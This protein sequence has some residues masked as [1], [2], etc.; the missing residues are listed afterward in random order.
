MQNVLLRVTTLTG[1]VSG[2]RFCGKSEASGACWEHAVSLTDFI[3][4]LQFPPPIREKAPFIRSLGEENGI[5]NV[6]LG[7]S[8]FIGKRGKQ[9]GPNCAEHGRYYKCGIN[10]IWIGLAQRG[11]YSVMTTKKAYRVCFC[12]YVC[13]RALACPMCIGSFLCRIC[14]LIML[15]AADV[16]PYTA[17]SMSEARSV[18]IAP[19]AAISGSQFSQSP[20]T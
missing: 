1:T 3:C 14:K 7:V 13:V 19:R 18:N 6:L 20:R 2:A 11:H 17:A 16:I 8:C 12:L 9:D 10:F 15:C 4:I 5:V